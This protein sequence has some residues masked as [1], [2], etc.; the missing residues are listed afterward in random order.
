MASK[1]PVSYLDMDREQI[2]D[3]YLPLVQRVV[4][5]MMLYGNGVIDREDL[6]S[7]G[8]IGLLNAIE[9]YDPAKGVRFETYAVSRIR[10]AILDELRKLNWHPRTVIDNMKRITAI[11]DRL[12]GT[13][14][15]WDYRI[16]A[17]ELGETENQVRRVVANFN[18][19]V[20]L[21]FDELVFDDETP[22]Q[23][24]YDLVADSEARD[25]QADLVNKERLKHLTDAIKKLDERDQLM[26]SLYYQEDLTLKE[27]G[28]ILEVTEGRVCQIHARAL[29]RLR[30]MM[31][32]D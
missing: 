11:Q 30:V 6:F 9:K 19:G 29:T 28:R 5:K 15:E 14:R 13:K 16:I 25:P 18:A 20:V 26:L 31:E 23:T 17:N 1:L 32:L 3:S 4:G 2:I 8:V 24:R 12:A 10:G 7:L 21:S 27:I 22:G